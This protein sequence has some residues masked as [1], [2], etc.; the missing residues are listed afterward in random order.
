MRRYGIELSEHCS[1]EATPTMIRS[2]DLVLAMAHEHVADALALAPDAAER[3]FTLRQLVRLGDQV[4][5]RPD[6]MGLSRWIEIVD[7]ERDGEGP[8][9]DDVPDPVGGP[10]RRYEA[11]A[12]ELAD[13]TRRLADLAWPQETV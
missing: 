7:S 1:Q 10:V 4:G 11:V 13:L 3:T 9:D 8:H 2:A 12:A 5:P 6:D